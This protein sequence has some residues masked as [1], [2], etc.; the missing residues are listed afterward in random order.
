[1]QCGNA[2]EKS[3]RHARSAA[4]LHDENCRI[5]HGETCGEGAQ[6]SKEICKAER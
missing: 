6:T 4:V 1:M 3:D 5:F 2:V